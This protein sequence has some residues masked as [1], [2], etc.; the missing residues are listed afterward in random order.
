MQIG[1]IHLYI[2]FEGYHVE[3]TLVFDGDNTPC[4]AIYSG[5]AFNQLRV[6]AAWA[7]EY[8]SD[9]THLP[10]AVFVEETVGTVK[11]RQ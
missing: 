10:D 2:H 9:G 7:E 5:T 4:S 1:M 6:T 3:L 11:G 8:L